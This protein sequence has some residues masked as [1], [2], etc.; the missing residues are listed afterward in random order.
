MYT[1][2]YLWACS[3]VISFLALSASASS[4]FCLSKC[5]LLCLTFQLHSWIISQWLIRQIS[6]E[7]HMSSG[8]LLVMTRLLAGNSNLF[9]IF[10]FLSNPNNNVRILVTEFYKETPQPSKLHVIVVTQARVHCLICTH[11][12]RGRVRTYQAMYECLCC[13]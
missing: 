3:S 5:L 8:S 4:I 6:A 9:H 7:H 11:D 1:Y 10:W 12:A 2:A 13:N